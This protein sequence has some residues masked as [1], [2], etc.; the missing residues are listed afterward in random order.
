MTHS[1]VDPAALLVAVLAVG[2]NPWTEAGPWYMI[3]TITALV[4]GV[5]VLCFTLPSKEQKEQKELKEQR[6]LKE[7]TEKKEQKDDLPSKRIVFAQS[8]VLG[9]IFSVF[10]SWPIQ[11]AISGRWL[12]T[13][14]SE[15]PTDQQIILADNIAL[16]TAGA[17]IIVFYPL[18]RWAVRRSTAMNNRPSPQPPSPSSPSSPPSPS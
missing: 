14:T 3:N 13:A 10:I 2:I 6:E 7:Q 4:V 5:V 11:G 15:K 16:I 8:V 17:L 12:L 18:L 9:F 1:K